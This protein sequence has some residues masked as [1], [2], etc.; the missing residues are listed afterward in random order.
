MAA[1]NPDFKFAANLSTMFQDLPFFQRFE[2]AKAK[3]F[4]HVEAQFLYEYDADELRKA[5]KSSGLEMVLIN[6][7]AGDFG[8][9][10][11][12]SIPGEEVSFQTSIQK[13]IVYAVATDCKKVN[14]LA[15]NRRR[16]FDEEDLYNCFVNNL[17][18]A[19]EI[20][21]EYNISAVIEPICNQVIENY[22]LDSFT[23]ALKAI[24]EIGSPNLE[25][26]LDFYHL[27]MMGLTPDD[28]ISL[29]INCTASEILITTCRVVQNF[30]APKNI[31]DIR[32]F[33]GLCSY[34]RQFIKDFCLK[35]QPLQ[36]LLKNDSKFTW[37]SDQKE[38]FE[39]LKTALA[40]EPVLGLFDEK[41]PTEL[42]ADASGLK[43]LS[44]R[45]TRW[46]LSLQEY[47]LEIVYKSGKKHK[48]ADSLSRNPVEDEVFPSEQKTT[49]ASFSDIAEEQRKDLEL[50][51]LIHT[52]E[53]AEP[54]TK[55]FNLIDRILCKK[56]FD[57]NGRKWLP[58]IPKH[59]RLEILQHFNDASTAGH[60]GSA[61][62]YNRIQ[63]CF[64]WPGLYRS[65]R[66]YV[67]HCRECQRRKS[68][69]QKPPGLLI[70]IPPASV[71]FQRIGIDL[72]KFPRSTKG[73]K[74]II[75]CT[76]YLSRFAV[77]KALPTAEAE[78]VAKF[79]TEEIALKHRAP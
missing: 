4:K 76:D 26:L 10:G 6:S 20:L 69:P 33:L 47:D 50:S 11:M 58:I 27:H 3:G 48:D 13:A 36:K 61:K 73:D 34:Y 35:A 52:H 57:P 14:I 31:R 22:F 46:A 54:V 70:P 32:S 49:L 55:I 79:I 59:L 12:A 43:D 16:G 44:G 42:H 41:A 24:K 66:R 56:N 18:S 2:A 63:K 60:L 37:G 7:P 65:V 25:L 8:T 15:G 23:T 28:G 17:R 19:V 64:F 72:G 39:K 29:Y 71:P 9:F 77:T 30:P 51:K 68:V 40:S 5:K 78:E 67:M 45:L 21:E 74:W 75:V 38:S 1:P 62:T 53:K